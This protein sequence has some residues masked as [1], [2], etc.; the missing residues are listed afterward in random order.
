MM[1]R[2]TFVVIALAVVTAACATDGSRDFA[3]DT[4][5]SVTTVTT[6]T[7]VTSEP[8]ETTSSTVDSTTT[9]TSTT[10]STTTVAPAS[11]EA[12]TFDALLTSLAQAPDLTSA[13]IE[14]SISITGLDPEAS[15]VAD[16][17]ILFGSAFDLSSGDSTFLM[18][19][20]SLA[21]AD[22][23]ADD[24]FGFDELA[25][26]FE[27]RTIDGRAYVRFP[28]FTDML[29]IETQWLSM[30]ADESVTMTEGFSMSPQDP[31][32]LLA[33]YEGAEASV[34]VLGRETVNEV[35]ATHYR[36]TVNTAYLVE[37]MTPEERAEIGDSIHFA[38][39]MVSMDLWTTDSGFVVR[40]VVEIDASEV[41]PLPGGE[42]DRITVQYDLFDVNAPISVVAPRASEVTSIEDLE[43][44]WGFDL[45]LGS[46]DD[47]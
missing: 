29:G 26:P 24:A 8:D 44:A 30:P 22:N 20:S 31:N 39:G 23:A 18:D 38:D 35:A 4:G 46:T 43:A 40:L 42:F 10:T 6:V 37:Q 7:T 33:D 14:G 47:A 41:E 15:G 1:K 21:D 36:I 2:L 3:D 28:L 32:D 27:V 19:M 9:T 12:P 25:E 45:D 11:S 13:R 17:E 34:E 16:A 5:G